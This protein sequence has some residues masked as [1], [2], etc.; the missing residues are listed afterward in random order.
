MVPDGVPDGGLIV[1]RGM[2]LSYGWWWSPLITNQVYIQF[3]SSVY[4]ISLHYIVIIVAAW[5]GEWRNG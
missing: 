3:L 2:K 5:N 1:T 4:I